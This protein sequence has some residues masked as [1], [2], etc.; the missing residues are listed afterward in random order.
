MA[1]AA[2][3]LRRLE[4]NIGVVGRSGTIGDVLAP[5]KVRLNRRRGNHVVSCIDDLD[6]IPGHITVATHG[7]LGEIAIGVREVGNRWRRHTGD[8]GSLHID[9][10]LRCGQLIA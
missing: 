3:R 9:D 10:M 5:G 8:S 2:V 1:I 6:C 7:D 4:E